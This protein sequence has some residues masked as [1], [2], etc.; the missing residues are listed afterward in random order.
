MDTHQIFSN[1]ND[2]DKS[3]L[4]SYPIHLQ[5]YGAITN[6][7][8]AGRFVDEYSCRILLIVIMRAYVSAIRH[9]PRCGLNEKKIKK[10]AKAG[11]K[12]FTMWF[13]HFGIGVKELSLKE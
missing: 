9:I 4:Y 3:I 2:I 8:A 5:A 10:I 7:G 13:R 11:R 12:E 1:L 6:K